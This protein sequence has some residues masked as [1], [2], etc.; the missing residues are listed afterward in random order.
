MIKLIFKDDWNGGDFYPSLK[1][2]ESI[3]LN[4]EKLDFTQSKVHGEDR[5]YNCVIK[6]SADDFKLKIET[7]Y[8]F[9]IEKSL[10][11]MI[12]NHDFYVRLKK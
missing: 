3:Y 11:E 12:K 9:T 8:G 2:V 7:T 5:D 1:D 4:G 6:W 10:R